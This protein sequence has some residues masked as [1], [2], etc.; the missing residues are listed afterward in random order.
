MG[1]TCYANPS[2]VKAII[3]LSQPKRGIAINKS[4][5][6]L[7]C[8]AFLVV[9]YIQEGGREIIQLVLVKKDLLMKTIRLVIGVRI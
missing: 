4:G 5:N 6:Y 9:S 8:I 1:L 2:L 3:H 7:S